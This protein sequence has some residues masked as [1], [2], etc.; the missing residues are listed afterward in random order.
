MGPTRPTNEQAVSGQVVLQFPSHVRQYT[1]LII[2]EAILAPSLSEPQ[3]ER[4]LLLTQAVV[5]HLAPVDLQLG[6][7]HLRQ[8]DLL[9]L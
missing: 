1:N 6:S 2:S 4:G 8:H 9:V 3:I 5:L 7:S